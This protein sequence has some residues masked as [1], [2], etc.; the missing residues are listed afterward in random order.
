MAFVTVA[1][2]HG[3]VEVVVFPEAYA[4]ASELIVTD[5]PILVQ[6]QVQKEESGVKILADTLIPMQKAAETWTANVHFRIDL[7][8]SGREQLEQ[9]KA[10]FADH[11]GNCK[12]FLHLFQDGQ[13]EA[14]VAL[15][16]SARIRPGRRMEREVNGLLG[17]RAVTTECS[18]IPVSNGNGGNGNGRRFG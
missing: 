16:D 13:A 1:D 7:A 4:A 2:L 12:G 14:I 11:R 8:R 6:G 3:S 15:P 5:A 9:L 18:P 10:L 17:Y